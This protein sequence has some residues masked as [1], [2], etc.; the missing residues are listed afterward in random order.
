MP[1]AADYYWNASDDHA[2]V[3]KGASTEFSTASM[4]QSD[5]GYGGSNWEFVAPG[6]VVHVHFQGTSRRVST[7]RIKSCDGATYDE[8]IIKVVQG[9]KGV[10]LGGLSKY[11][12]AFP[13]HG[14]FLARLHAAMNS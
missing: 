10:N 11:C 12:A 3:K 8:N 1:S 5:D 4:I 9:V 2:A 7:V 14:A 13:N 6:L